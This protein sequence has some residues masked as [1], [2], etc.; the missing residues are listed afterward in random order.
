MGLLEQLVSPLE[1]MVIRFFAKMSV[2]YSEGKGFVMH[3]RA[4]KMML[5]LPHTVMPLGQQVM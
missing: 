3:L 4:L 2:K 5:V 1:K